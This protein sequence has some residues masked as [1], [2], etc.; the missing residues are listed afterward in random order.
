MATVS[1]SPI[2]LVVLRL[3]ARKSFSFGVWVQDQNERPLDISGCSIRFVARKKVA[4]TVNDDS[5]N[6]ITNSV[7]VLTAPILG[8]A[9]FSF[10]ASELDWA[11]G[12]YQFAV[13]LSDEGYSATIIQ[14]VIELEGNTEFTSMTET[15][16]TVT[17]STS[18][19]AIMRESVAI[20]VTT[21]ATLAPG[22]ATF[23]IEDEKKLDQVFAGMLADGQVLNADLIPDGAAKVMMTTA[24]RFK[25]ANLTLEWVDINGKPDFGDIITH[26]ASE[27]ALKNDIDAGEINSGVIFKDRLP[28]V[29]AQR[30]ISDGTGAP[31]SGQPYTIYLKHA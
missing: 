2:D 30:G 19:R 28:Y 15:Y 18:L 14:G 6:L 31:P 12:E 27:F 7:A 23:T 1:N 8:Y 5:D 11:P 26:D 3:Q 22:Q 9:V 10:Q 16:S 4:S 17:P 25:L 20:K 21:G 24:E 29:I 13:V